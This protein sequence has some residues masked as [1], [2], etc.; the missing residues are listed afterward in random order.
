MRFSIERDA[1]LAAARRAA[2]VIKSRNTIP[3][4]ACVLIEAKDNALRISASNIDMWTTATVEAAGARNGAACIDA[5]KL[6]AWLT[7]CPKN[8][9][10]HFDMNE[11]GVVAA[12]AGGLAATMATLPQEDFPVARDSDKGTEVAGFIPA[13]RTCL[14]FASREETRY[15]M[16]GVAISQGSAVATDAHRACAVAIGAPPEIA[17]IVPSAAC[18]VIAS[19]GPDARL[20]VSDRTWSCEDE[21]FT[22]AGKLIDGTYPDWTRVFGEAD[23]A[24]EADADDLGAA[25]L[26]VLMAS[27]ERS[28]GVLMKAGGETLV[29]TCRSVA[30]MATAEVAWSG[31]KFSLG[32]NA[33]Y[34]KDALAPFAGNV[35]KIA[36]DEE[37][38]LLTCGAVPSVRVVVMG[39][40]V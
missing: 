30:M 20:W 14:P 7:A 28:K 39:M 2:A 3:V 18:A 23:R 4:L 22:S 37:K 29:L 24:G 26:S 6:V 27:D 13:M 1:F 10:V 36:T 19:A 17:A 33:R 9:L 38:C 25:F 40:R 12:S 21:G 5:A 11:N 31:G 32:I 35:V 15:H 16:C 34:A 8:T